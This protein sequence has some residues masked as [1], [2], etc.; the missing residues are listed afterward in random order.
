MV[1]FSELNAVNDILEGIQTLPVNEITEDDESIFAYNVLLR[2]KLEVLSTGWSF[3]TDTDII[4]TPDING[5]IYAPN[6][7][8]SYSIRDNRNSIKLVKD[9]YYDKVNNTYIFTEDLTISKM[10]LDIEF[11][12]LPIECQS[13]IMQVSRLS[14]LLTNTGDTAL[15]R[16]YLVQLDEAKGTLNN[17]EQRTYGHRLTG[18]YLV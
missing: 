6:N 5:F 9:R 13:Y 14:F 3:N 15:Y 18:G 10:V 4:L 17:F 8:L 2:K 1:N 12:D 16:N 11:E 7:Q